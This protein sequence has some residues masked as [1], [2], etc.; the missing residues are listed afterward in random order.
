MH[1]H[2]HKRARTPQAVRRRGSIVS[3]CFTQQLLCSPGSGES[4]HL[5]QKV[6]LYK[7]FFSSS[8]LQLRKKKSPNLLPGFVSLSF[9]FY[10]FMLFLTLIKKNPSDCFSQIFASGGAE[11]DFD[12]QLM[13][14]LQSAGLI[15]LIISCSLTGQVEVE[16]KET[17]DR[18]LTAERRFLGSF[19]HLWVNLLFLQGILNNRG[20]CVIQTPSEMV[21]NRPLNPCLMKNNLKF[22]SECK[23]L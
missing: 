3:L 23:V 8:F 14:T 11:E 20:V 9:L 5:Q 22:S 13:L 19:Q 16:S 10:I 4:K 6:G 12:L 2:Q 7:R 1:F 17:L 21:F 15:W 18:W